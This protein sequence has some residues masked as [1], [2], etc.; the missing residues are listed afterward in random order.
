MTYGN[1]ISGKER[2]LRTLSFQETDRV[3]VIPVTHSCSAKLVGYTLGEAITNPKKYVESQVRCLDR[4]GYDG[5]WGIA[6]SEVAEALG[7][8]II[9]H[10]DDIPAVGKAR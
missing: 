6:V 5:V 1:S 4:F 9:V 8:E 3:P 2:V 10:D 7:C